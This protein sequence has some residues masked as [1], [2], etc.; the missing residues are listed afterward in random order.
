MTLVYRPF[1]ILVGVNFRT[2]LRRASNRAPRLSISAARP[3]ISYRTGLSTKSLHLV[4][5]SALRI[6]WFLILC[7]F[8]RIV[9]SRVSE[10]PQRMPCVS[11]EKLVTVFQKGLVSEKN[12]TGTD[13]KEEKYKNRKPRKKIIFIKRACTRDILPN[14]ASLTSIPPVL[15]PQI[16][17]NSS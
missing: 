8:H 12:R 16:K 3:D 17:S 6:F 13:E 2:H 10:L 15:V 5:L 1:Q 9:L 4:Y 7:R 11:E 14:L